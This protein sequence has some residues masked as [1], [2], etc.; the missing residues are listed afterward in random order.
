MMING[1]YVSHV[2]GHNLYSQFILFLGS[3]V[4][5]TIFVRQIMRSHISFPKK[6][7]KNE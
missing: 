2:K 4:R 5:N 6:K 7:T 1:I 3:F